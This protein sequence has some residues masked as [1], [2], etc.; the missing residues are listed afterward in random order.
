[1]ERSYQVTTSN[2]NLFFK[3]FWFSA[4]APGKISLHKSIHEL[5]E[6]SNSVLV[7]RRMKIAWLH[8]NQ[9]KLILSSQ[10]VEAVCMCYS[11]SILC[12]N[13]GDQSFEIRERSQ[14][15]VVHTAYYTWSPSFWRRKRYNNYHY[16]SKYWNKMNCFINPEKAKG[17][18]M[19]QAIRFRDS[20]TWA[21]SMR[22]L[23]AIITAAFEFTPEC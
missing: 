10:L 8:E 9:F 16:L 14:A 11:V 19:S 6:I 17:I 1:V 4:F 20:I 21:R 13:G 3:G 22:S 7:F 12:R 15:E 2:W 18:K 23:F 5:L